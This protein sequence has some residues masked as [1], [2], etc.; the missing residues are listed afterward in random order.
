MILH[1]VLKANGLKND[2]PQQHEGF[3]TASN[4]VMKKHWFV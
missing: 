1:S 2:K 3:E 4:S